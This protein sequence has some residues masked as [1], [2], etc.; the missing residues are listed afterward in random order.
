MISSVGF[1]GSRRGMNDKQR[2]IVY[3]LLKHYNPSGIETTDFHHGDCLGSDAEANDIAHDLG[4]RVII[5]PPENEKFRAYCEGHVVLMQ[6]G[7]IHRDQK[8]VQKAKVMLATPHGNEVLHSGTWTT[9]RYSKE[10]GRM[11]H[12]I[13]PDG[14][15]VIK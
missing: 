10:I 8:I 7:Y 14:K 15:V 11:I 4:Y 5:H 2:E 6:R 1:T 9:I 12:I 13:Y 3:N